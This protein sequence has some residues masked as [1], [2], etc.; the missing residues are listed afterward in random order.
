MKNV[1]LGMI[2]LSALL[3]T[4]ISAQSQYVKEGK[5]WTGERSSSMADYSCPVIVFFKGDTLIGSEVYK[6]QYE[7]SFAIGQGQA[8]YQGGWREADGRTYVV[9]PGTDREELAMDYSLKLGEIW[10][11]KDIIHQVVATSTVFVHGKERRIQVVAEFDD[12][13]APSSAVYSVLV[14]GIGNPYQM[15]HTYGWSFMGVN[16]RLF[17]C[18]ED[19]K[20]VLDASDFA[21]FSNLL[22]DIETVTP[23]PQNLKPQLSSLFDLQG[24]RLTQAPAKGVFIQNGKKVT[25]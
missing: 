23:E 20:C 24:R 19:D 4:H 18:Y 16:T 3:P 14:E 2:L 7:T 9:F 17:A 12:S 13:D 10:M 5:V 8:E 11:F 25:Y 22:D 15:G 6:K 21:S 1:Y